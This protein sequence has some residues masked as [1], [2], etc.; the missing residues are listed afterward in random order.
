MAD[1]C[2]YYAD[3]RGLIGY[4]RKVVVSEVWMKGRR[5]PKQRAVCEIS[6]EWLLVDELA[7]AFS[8]KFTCEVEVPR[9]NRGSFADH[10]WTGLLKRA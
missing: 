2:C 5:G 8:K 1:A 10:V 3:S 6:L 7:D 4:C 9:T